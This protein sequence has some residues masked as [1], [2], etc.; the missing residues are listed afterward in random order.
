MD[1]NTPGFLIHHQLLELA[2]THV[3]RV[4][5]VLI[6]SEAPLISIEMSQ[7]TFP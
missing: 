7:I 6:L 4:G 1:C 2:Q 3:H 5:D